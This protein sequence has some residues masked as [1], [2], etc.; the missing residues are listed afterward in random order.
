MVSCLHIVENRAQ[1]QKRVQ[2]E[3]RA[4]TAIQQVVKRL[5]GATPENV[6]LLKKELDE[7]LAKDARQGIASEQC[8]K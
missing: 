2:I 5:N 8:R 1:E 4:W 6:D 7:T 3:N